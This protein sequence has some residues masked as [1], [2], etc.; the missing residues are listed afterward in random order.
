[1]RPRS[2]PISKAETT[3][4]SP[5]HT[6]HAFDS[7]PVSLR[8]LKRKTGHPE[9]GRLD[10]VSEK[11]SRSDTGDGL[12]GAIDGHHSLARGADGQR[13]RGACAKDSANR[14]RREP[15]GGTWPY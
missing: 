12:D 5:R 1:M 7:L 3:I 13:R 14:C 11:H 15:V 4:T 8:V 10:R 9:A 6:D 2:P